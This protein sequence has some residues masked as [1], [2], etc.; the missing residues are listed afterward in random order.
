[1]RK[2][3]K[4]LVRHI[5]NF[6]EFLKYRIINNKLSSTRF[7][8]FGRG[9]SGSTALVSL[10]NSIPKIH[11]EGEILNKPV[12]FP[13]SHVL[14]KCGNS[15]SNIYGCKIL[16]YQI[17]DVQ[18]INDREGFIRLLHKNGFKI[19]Y[20]RRENLIHHALSNI[21]A[22]KFG[23]HT[24]NSQKQP[25]KKIVLDLD[26]L[27]MWIKKSEEL[28][29][30]ETHLLQGVPHL[31]LTYERNILNKYN[32]QETAKLICKFLGITYNKAKTKYIKI[33]PR[34]LQDS[35][36]NYNELVEF[37]KNTQYYT[38]L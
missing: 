27:M 21:R 18:P 10:L 8:I 12:M 22:R 29:R 30:Y 3:K 7:V 5:N 32:H 6:S 24:K 28:G 13:S 20:L 17:K 1:M 19:L 33:S 31:S 38:Y 35:V 15:R 37:L 11:C 36:A 16:S 34:R 26:E 25:P 9:R 14:A 23:F 2:N 4:S